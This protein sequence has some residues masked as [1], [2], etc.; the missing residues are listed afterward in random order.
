MDIFARSARSKLLEHLGRRID[1]RLSSQ[2]LQRMLRVPY[3]NRPKQLGEISA[4]FRELE[5]FEG[6]SAIRR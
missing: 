5:S 2:L 4:G 3:V 1:L 6:F